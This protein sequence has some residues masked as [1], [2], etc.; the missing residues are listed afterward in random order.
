L[1]ISAIVHYAK[2][3]YCLEYRTGVEPILLG[4]QSRA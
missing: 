1:E 3:A 2:P 4:L